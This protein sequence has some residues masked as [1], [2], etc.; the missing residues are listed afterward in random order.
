M[1]HNSGEQ[2]EIVRG[3]GY[4]YNDIKECHHCILQAMSSNANICKIV[5]FAK[6]F[7]AENFRR[8]IKNVVRLSDYQ[9]SWR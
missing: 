1:V 6:K 8:K 2:R 3:I 4:V 9:N 7:S 5:D